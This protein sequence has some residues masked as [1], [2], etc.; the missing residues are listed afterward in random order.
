MSA[1]YLGHMTSYIPTI[2]HD[3]LIY[4][5]IRVADWPAAVRRAGPR[6]VI[7]VASYPKG[8]RRDLCIN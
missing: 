2:H 3:V 4:V 6:H 5:L 7:D 1:L 8:C